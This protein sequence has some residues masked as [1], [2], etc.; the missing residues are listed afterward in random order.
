MASQDFLRY[1]NIRVQPKK[2]T[3]LKVPHERTDSPSDVMVGEVLV[4]LPELY[5]DLLLGK[6][7]FFL[8]LQR[9]AKSLVEP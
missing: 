5:C 2:L 6:A 3:E 7:V 1:F 9:P 8:E 4:G